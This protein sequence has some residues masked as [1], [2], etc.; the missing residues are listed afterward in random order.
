MFKTTDTNLSLL[1][2]CDFYCYRLYGSF[3]A[4]KGGQLIDALADMTGGVAEH[5]DIKGALPTLPA[6][7][8][9]VLYKALDRMSLIS[10]NIDVS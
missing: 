3:E 2:K 10:C 9:N 7:I 8:V 6:N 1:S 5:Y 4:L